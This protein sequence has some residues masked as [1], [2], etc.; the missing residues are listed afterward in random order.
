MAM[1]ERGNDGIRADA[2]PSDLVDT[3]LSEIALPIDESRLREALSAHARTHDAL[4]RVRSIPLQY[5]P[6][7]V[8]PMTALRWIENGGHSV[9]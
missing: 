6:T 2:L 1:A 7:Y 3:L 9:E 4:M 8:E 5:S